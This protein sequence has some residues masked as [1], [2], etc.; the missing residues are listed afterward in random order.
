MVAA[1]GY[2]AKS[3]QA[4]VLQGGKLVDMVGASALVD[5]L[6][7]DPGIAAGR[8]Q[9]DGRGADHLQA[10]FV[11]LAEAGGDP[12]A[13]T[14]I[15]RAG[16]ALTLV[17][18]TATLVRFRAIWSLHVQRTMPGLVFV[19]GL[20]SGDEALPDLLARLEAELTV[21]RNLPP[22][23]APLHPP[24]I[25][26]AGR[27]GQAAVIR[28]GKRDDEA[29]AAPTA[30]K[31]AAVLRDDGGLTPLE[32]RCLPR[33]RRDGV[34]FPRD[35][36]ADAEDDRR[37]PFRGDNRAIAIVHAD[38]NGLG[39]RLVS[40]GEQ[41]RTLGGDLAAIFSAVSRALAQ[42]TEV[43]VQSAHDGMAAAADR[44]SGMILGDGRLMLGS[45][46]LV[47]GGDDVTAILRADL[48]MDWVERFLLTFADETRSRFAGV[49]ASL[50]DEGKS[51]GAALVGRLFEGGLTAGAGVVFA[52]ATQPFDQAYV[53]CESLAKHAKS[54]AKALD[55]SLPPSTISFHRVTS[56]V[57][58]PYDEI[59][60]SDLTGGGGS[61]RLTANPYAVGA[62]AA[63]L[64]RLSD[65]RA[66]ASIIGQRDFPSGP[67][68][69]YAGTL[70]RDEFAA[71]GL[72]ARFLQV[73]K[74]RLPRRSTRASRDS[75]GNARAEERMG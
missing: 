71:A 30:A 18:E 59:L 25:H 54:T 56:A 12:H 27:T 26:R 75:S 14:V 74:K 39:Q 40:L 9:G 36:E 42:A 10:A 13:V 60:R 6:A 34:L 38:G 11:A 72:L 44:R 17:G 41:G 31:R 21:S 51:D 53:L 4:Y 69:E 66:L 22:A 70:S 15:R 61:L 24:G 73:A 46:P 3:I 32:R 52:R 33:G 23:A 58:S 29:I 64:M 43:A 63:T 20:V 7:R 67:L 48:A 50:R 49:A 28:D 16:G 45:R 68:R 8:G 55:P 62:G 35:F 65:V 1:Y 47:V 37:F 19:D 57:F 5:D 2:Q